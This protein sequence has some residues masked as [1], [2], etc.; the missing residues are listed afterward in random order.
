MHKIGAHVSTSGGYTNCFKKIKEMGGN[1]FQCFSSPPRGWGISSPSEETVQEFL[2]TKQEYQI[3]PIYFHATYLI[4][5]ADNDRIGASSVKNLTEELQLASKLHVKG[6]IIHAGSFKDKME[7]LHSFK[8]HEKYSVL[9]TNIQNVLSA[10]P[11]DV[12]FIIENAGTRKIGRTIDE[13]GQI[14]KDLQS[15]Q[16]KVCLDTCHLHASG[17]DLSTT[18]KLNEFLEKF[19]DIVGIKNLELFH[20]NDSRDTFDSFR[21]RHD[22]LGKGLIGLSVFE[23]VINHKQLQHIPF[24]L[25]VPGMAGEGP[26]KENIDILKGLITNVNSK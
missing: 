20:I 2:K 26:D 10:I 6:S 19:D 22:N 24:I 13:I 8:T 7:N 21:D 5:L 16:V 15:P 18:E 3:D 4:N 23:N 25:E 14:I 9:L 11:K 12:S 17:Y 1:C